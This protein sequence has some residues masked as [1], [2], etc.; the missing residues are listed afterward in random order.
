MTDSRRR[1]ASFALLMCFSTGC[2]HAPQPDCIVH[3]CPVATA[4]RVSVTSSAGGPV[5]G[6]TLTSSGAAS[7][8]GQCAVGQSAT[9]CV[10][11][12]MPGTYNLQLSAAGFQDKTVAV[13]VPGSTPPCGC[14]AVETQQ[15]S[16]VLEAM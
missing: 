10:V 12:G 9:S 11:P 6:L 5:P 7:G 2:G 8:S 3:P 15:V 13:V 4:I 1:L 16:V 14:V